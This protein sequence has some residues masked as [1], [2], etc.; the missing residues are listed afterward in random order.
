MASSNNTPSAERW[1]NLWAPWRMEYIDALDS[2]NDDC[3]LCRY[4]DTPA[5]DERSL[6][7][8]RRERTM[9]VMNRFPYTGGHLLVAPM[10]HVG[11]MRDLSDAELTEL[12]TTL[13][14]C[15]DL[16]GRAVKAEG[17]NVGFNIGHCA[18]AGLPGHIH[19]H[20]V[21]RWQGDT[22][23]MTVLGDVRVIPQALEALYRRL[24]ETAAEMGLLE[25]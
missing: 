13:R 5:D 3:F 4:R 8:Y 21:P 9:V 20:V 14:D 25:T 7:V 11:A 19:M 18:G 12:M 10:A 17:Y 15:Q 23:F 22:N 1:V 24:R 6:V 2:G 16:L